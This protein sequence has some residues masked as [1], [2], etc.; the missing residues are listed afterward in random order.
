MISRPSVIGIKRLY[1]SVTRSAITVLFRRASRRY[2]SRVAVFGD[3]AEKLRAA[4]EKSVYL[5]NAL[6]HCG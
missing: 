4:H 2:A 6:S 5:C 1:I 3:P